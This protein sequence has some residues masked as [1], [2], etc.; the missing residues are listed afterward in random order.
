MR[1]LCWSNIDL[2]RR[3]VPIVQSKTG[4]P[5]TAQLSLEAVNALLAIRLDGVDRVFAAGKGGMR[6]WELRLFK[7]AKQYGFVRQSRQALGTLRKSHATE[8]C[9]LHGLNAAA[10]SLGHVSGA[11]IARAHYVQ[12]DAMRPGSLPPPLPLVS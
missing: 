5:H 11:R 4:H 3:L 2:A 7:H 8:V 6:R 1:R 9:R 12:P 10:E